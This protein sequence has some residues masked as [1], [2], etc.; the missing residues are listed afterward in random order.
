MRRSVQCR[1]EAACAH[2]TPQAPAAV[3]GPRQ[4]CTQKSRARMHRCRKG[5]V[6]EQLGVTSSRGLQKAGLRP[7][8]WPPMSAQHVQPRQHTP[9]ARLRVPNQHGPLSQRRPTPICLCSLL[10]LQSTARRCELPQPPHLCPPA[11]LHERAQRASVCAISSAQLAMSR[12]GMPLASA[13]LR[14]P[15]LRT[16][17][18]APPRAARCCAPAPCKPRVFTSDPQAS[19]IHLRP[20]TLDT[21]IVRV[22]QPDA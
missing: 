15:P 20:K 8:A 6:Q 16:R 13:P 3:A 12:H 4:G 9:R 22:D 1:Q 21:F 11:V 10:R 2:T 17:P 5:R 7:H 14:S 18:P 19:R